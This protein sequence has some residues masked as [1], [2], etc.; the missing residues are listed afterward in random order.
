MVGFYRNGFPP[1]HA[2]R[3]ILGRLSNSTYVISKHTDL[4]YRTRQ[5][6]SL[7]NNYF[8]AARACLAQE[9]NCFCYCVS[10]CAWGINELPG[11]VRELV[12]NSIF[13]LTPIQ[14]LTLGLWV[15]RGNHEKGFSGTWNCSLCKGWHCNPSLRIDAAGFSEG[16][17]KESW[18]GKALLEASTSQ[19]WENESGKEEKEE[20][21]ETE[22]DTDDSFSA[23]DCNERRT[24]IL[25]R[26]A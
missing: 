8:G 19:G 5:R 10:T 22:T 24:E 18:A 26:D 20:E 6:S 17:Q 23:P 3:S 21:F 12:I 13:G 1:I 9:N 16:Q 2:I 14:K 7:K 15:Q 4:M 25:L 11:W